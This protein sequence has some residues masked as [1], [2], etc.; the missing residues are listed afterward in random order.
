VFI[1]DIHHEHL[2]LAEAK[3]WVS[4]PSVWWIP[5]PIALVDFPVPSNDDASKAISYVV[6]YLVAAINEGLE[7]RRA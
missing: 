7:E 1:V 2:A 3:N 5:T 4:K 6:N